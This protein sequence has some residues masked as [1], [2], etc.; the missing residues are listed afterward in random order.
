MA[1]KLVRTTNRFTL[2]E[3]VAVANKAA[4]TAGDSRIKVRT[5]RWYQA[6]GLFP[7]P[8][9]FDGPA[10][11]YEPLDVLRLVAIIRLQ[12]HGHTIEAIR[13][14]V[15]TKAADLRRVAAITQKRVNEIAAAGREPSRPRKWQAHHAD[16]MPL[17][18]R[19]RCPL[20]REEITRE[21]GPRCSEFNPKCGCCRA[22]QD[23][24]NGRPIEVLVERD[25]LVAAMQ[26]L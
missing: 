26:M 22:W 12:D 9:A 1:T 14:L 13:Q 17:W 5:V 6:I 23:H 18:V 11:L 4:G 10:G 7:G 15:P 16:S 20:T 24:S 8:R 2:Q 19:V 25:R 3:L 21:F